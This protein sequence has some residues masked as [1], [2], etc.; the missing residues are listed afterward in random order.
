VVPTDAAGSVACLRPQAKGEG[1]GTGGRRDLQLEI[2]SPW[3][4]CVDFRIPLLAPGPKRERDRN[5]EPD[6][7]HGALNRLGFASALEAWDLDASASSALVGSGEG[8]V[9]LHQLLLFPGK[10]RDASSSLRRDAV[11]RLPDSREDANDRLRYELF[12]IHRLACP[13]LAYSPTRIGVSV[14]K[15][16]LGLAG[17]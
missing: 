9:E 11:L 2:R 8:D 17:L 1:G 15:G 14:A 4:N 16:L 10:V 6:P 12:E 5:L 3:K 7:T 13:T